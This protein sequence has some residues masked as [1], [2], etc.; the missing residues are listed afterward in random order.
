ML[1]A[2]STQKPR[3]MVAHQDPRLRGG[4]QVGSK[5]QK[6]EMAH[7]K[8]FEPLASAFGGG[9]Y[10]VTPENTVAS[11]SYLSHYPAVIFLL[12]PFSLT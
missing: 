1:S 12:W 5:E 3:A 7:P 6:E 10:F 8:G 11:F 4:R 9:T 2:P